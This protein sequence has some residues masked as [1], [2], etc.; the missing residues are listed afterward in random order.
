[1]IIMNARDLLLTATSYIFLSLSILGPAHANL[2]R[3]QG[4][5]DGTDGLVTLGLDTWSQSIFGGFSS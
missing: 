1:M 2:E 5:L 3:D 4:R